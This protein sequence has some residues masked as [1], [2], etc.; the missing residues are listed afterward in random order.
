[1]LKY[2]SNN[3]FHWKLQLS[4]KDFNFFIF[5]FIS[6]QFSDYQKSFKEYLQFFKKI[7]GYQI[8]ESLV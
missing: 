1:M 6:K 2:L 7:G 5:E 8:F 3:T 4:A